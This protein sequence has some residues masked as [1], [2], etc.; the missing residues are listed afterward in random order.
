ML[1]TF[2]GVTVSVAQVELGRMVASRED[3]R[4]NRLMS[5]V[6]EAGRADVYE[7]G[8][9]LVGYDTK[10]KH[11]ANRYIPQ[12][13]RTDDP[14]QIRA[15]VHFTPDIQLEGYYKESM[16]H[17]YRRTMSVEIP[18]AMTGELM[19][20]MQAT[21]EGEPPPWPISEPAAKD[22]YGSRYGSDPD[23]EEIMAWVA[24]V[25]A[26]RIVSE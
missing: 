24:S 23:A 21:F 11:Y 16:V 8:D 17:A 14:T 13:H 25:W 3:A 2:L 6:Y 12:A 4:V 22:K 18:A 1:L 20:G 19:L 10:T 5:E 15:V 9:G 26:E 7:A